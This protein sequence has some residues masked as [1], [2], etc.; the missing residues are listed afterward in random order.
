MSLLRPALV[1]PTLALA[2]LALAAGTAAQTKPACV[3][4]WSEARAR[5]V[6]YDHV[7]GIENLCDKPAHCTIS[8]DVAP[9]PI[10]AT[11]DPKKS[12]E[13]TTFRSSPAREFKAKI[14]CRTP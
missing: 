3:R 14:D 10:E 6:G 9:D 11:V 13:L 12:V 2:L 8:T 1:A 5:A 4:T 7:V